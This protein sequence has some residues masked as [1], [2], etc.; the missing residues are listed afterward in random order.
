MKK[1]KMNMDFMTVIKRHMALVVPIAILVVALIVILLAIMKTSSNKKMM[2]QS[3]R[4]GKKVSSLAKNTPSEKQWKRVQLFQANHK[5]DADAILNLEKETT[6]RE[7]ISYKIFP[8]PKDKSR[9][10]FDDFS[11]KYKTAILD[12]LKGV[13]SKDAPHIAEITSIIGGAGA[14]GGRDNLLGRGGIPTT[15]A[16]VP[17][18]VDAFCNK[19][20]QSIS[21]YANPSSLIWYNYWENFEF[22]GTDEAVKDCW[23]SQIAYWVYSD[24][25]AT[26]NALNS[27]S[28]SVFTSPVK[29]LMGVSFA[30]PVQ[31]GVVSSGT[32]TDRRGGGGVTASAFSDVPVFFGKKGVPIFGVEPWT[33]R[34]TDD[35]SDVMH[36]NV[37]V[38][39][40]REVVMPFLKELC[41]V[42]SHAFK[43]WDG[44]GSLRDGL[45]HNQITV[46]NMV[47]KSVDSRSEDHQYYRYGSQPVI[48]LSLIC[49]YIFNR[50]AYATIMPEAVKATID[51]AAVSSVTPE[52]EE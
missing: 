5:N 25:F 27:D 39:I 2:E 46:L 51:G 20:A 30:S 45:E 47:A 44:S 40:P 37:S 24:V 15:G 6:T 12:L 49:E 22:K 3:V 31:S 1:L 48:E 52:D 50:D 26:I 29:R 9:Q 33:T 19:R 10:L 42:K 16:K 38:V 41:S 11:V 14:G 21:V 8:E 28:N 43:G 18:A 17:P 32:T 4:D 13:N 7:L 34:K 36:F 23:Y 35:K